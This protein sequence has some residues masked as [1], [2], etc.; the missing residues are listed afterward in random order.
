MAPPSIKSILIVGGGSA[1]WM[2]AA[3]LANKLA[4]LP[5]AIGLLESAEIGT[6]GVG[7]ATLPHIRFFNAA[8]GFDEAEF[9][10]RTKATFK[11]GI[12]FRNWGRIGDSYIHPFGAFGTELGGVPFHQHWLR[13]RAA[14]ATV[15]LEHYSLPI[16]AARHDRFAHPA[17]DPRSLH[18][19]YSYAY[20]FDAGL[21]GRFLRDYAEQRGVERTEGRIV[22]VALRPEDGFISSLTLAGGRLLEAD[23]FIDCSGF[24]GVLIEQALGAGYEEWTRW[25]PCDGAIAVPCA[26]EGPLTP[27]TRATAHSSG[28]MWRIPLQ[29]RVGNGHVYSSAFIDDGD[30]ESALLAQLEAPPLAEP[31][32]LRFT[33]GKR[34]C[35]WAKNCVAIGL[36]AGFLE[37]LESTGIHLIQLAIGHLIDLLPDSGW[38]PLDAA[39]FNRMMDLEYERV[40]DFLILHYCATER[41][42][43]P[44]W[45]HCR[46]MDL[47]DSIHSRM[48]L[49]RERGYV[50]NYREGMFLEPSWIAVYLGQNVIPR[51][52]DPL[53][54]AVP[55]SRL[56][57]EMSR[58]G[59]ACRAAAERM[60]RHDDFLRSIG[61]AA[62][63]P[64]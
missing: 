55:E 13:M 32:R 52:F 23:L 54:E 27:Y 63:G 20:Q 35:H 33:T 56:R 2:T 43:T 6:V 41:D 44:F 18:S 47:P 9:M 57:A 10:R 48:E 28:W 61:A 29:H 1:G 11:L 59:E 39:E 25:L 34:R 42:D 7:E 49:F 30:A 19:T 50:V 4:G 51:R 38:D 36:S 46:T 16:Q 62:E 5:I 22:D 45:N 14:G 40:R 24:R 3:A 15:P 60:P 53:S 26:G 17:D 12:E 58:I 8:L 37:P 64:A 31:N 21:Y